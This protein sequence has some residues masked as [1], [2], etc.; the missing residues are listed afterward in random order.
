MPFSPEAPKEW[1]KGIE[2]RLD[3]LWADVIGRLRIAKNFPSMS[4]YDTLACA[5][6]IETSCLWNDSAKL[7]IK[8][9]YSSFETS[10][11]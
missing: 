5:N 2:A 1:P 9:F 10:T 3:D 6:I 11:S 8:N 4:K 7:L